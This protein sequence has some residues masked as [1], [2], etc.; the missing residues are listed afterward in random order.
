[1]IAALVFGLEDHGGRA[2]A[3]LSA[4]AGSGDPAADDRD[5]EIHTAGYEFESRTV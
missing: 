1:M 4:N 2:V 5:V 3:K